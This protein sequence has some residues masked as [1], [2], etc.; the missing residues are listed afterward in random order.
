MNLRSKNGHAL[1]F[2]III[3]LFGTQL[4]RLLMEVLSITFNTTNLVFVIGLLLL[5]PFCREQ[6]NFFVMDKK[7]LVIIFYQLFVW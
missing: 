6:K 7:M 2:G 3:C 1:E 5:V 4:S